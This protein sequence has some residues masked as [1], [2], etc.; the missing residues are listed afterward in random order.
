MENMEDLRKTIE[1]NRKGSAVGLYSVCSSNRTVLEASVS[2]AKKDN[3]FLFVESTSNQVNQFGGYTGM[4]AEDFAVFIRELAQSSGF[5]FEKIVLGGDHLGPN[6]WQ[7]EKAESAMEKAEALV[8]SCVKAGYKKIHLDASMFC[9]DDAGDRTKPLSDEISAERT[10]RLCKAC[11]DTAEKLNLKEAKDKPLYIIGTEV[12]VPGGSK[13]KETFIQP[14][15][16]E[17][18]KNT[19]A[20]MEEAFVKAGLEDAWQR[21]IAVVAQ[22]GVE[23]GD[24]HVFY[25]DREKAKNLS[26]ALNDIPLVFEA[27]STDYQTGQNLKHMVED[28]F[29]ILKVGPALSYAYREALFS[30]AKMEKELSFK[31]A[32][33]SNLEETA[34][35]VMLESSPN[36]WVKYYHGTEEEKR[37]ARKFSLSDRIRYYWPHKQLAAA[38]DKLFNNLSSIDI[39]FTLVSQYMPH[40][41]MSFR[42]GTVG[43][44][45]YD[46]VIA[47]IRCILELY[48]SSCGYKSNG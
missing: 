40:L 22:P 41:S 39:P 37:F 26:R 11:E 7:G 45:P 3:A 42:E 5:P 23:F 12:P 2:Q 36:Y 34:E 17:S 31:I 30:L 33:L 28:H 20:A 46:L 43:K 10:A 47:H 19:I 8:K 29:C 18:V 21:V 38:V 27:H 48:S 14:T 13:E 24:D 9:L 1:L 16:P 4:Q 6:V 44:R 25:Y 15:S 35:K 32:S